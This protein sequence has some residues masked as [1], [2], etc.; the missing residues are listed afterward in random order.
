MRPIRHCMGVRKYRADGFTIAH[1]AAVFDC[2]GDLV[3]VKGSTLGEK[4]MRGCTRCVVTYTER[5]HAP[6]QWWR[7]VVL[8]P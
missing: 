4:L 8:L 6:V 5:V 1:R 2:S 3:N 7:R